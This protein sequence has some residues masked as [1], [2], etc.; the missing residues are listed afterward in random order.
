MVGVLIRAAHEMGVEGCVDRGD[1]LH[2][3]K[4]VPAEVE[5][6]FVDSNVV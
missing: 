2:G 5:K 6:R 1:G 3:G 4:R